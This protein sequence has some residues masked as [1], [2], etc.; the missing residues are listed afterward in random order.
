MNFIETLT[1]YLVLVFVFDWSIY[2]KP[3]WS[4][5]SYEDR[6]HNQTFTEKTNLY[7]IHYIFIYTIFHISSQT[8]ILLNDGKIIQVLQA[9]AN[10]WSRL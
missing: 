4:S 3:I 5:C 6:K 7:K 8:L 9:R 2:F 1:F 10:N